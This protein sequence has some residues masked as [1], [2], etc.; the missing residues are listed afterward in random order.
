MQEL[1]IKRNGASTTP[2]QSAPSG[3][4]VTLPAGAKKL[5]IKTFGCQMNEYDSEKMADILN[6]E[7]GLELTENPEEAVFILLN[8]CSIREKAQE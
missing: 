2:P 7:Q 6:A 4:A 8:T 3:E 1:S 5:Y